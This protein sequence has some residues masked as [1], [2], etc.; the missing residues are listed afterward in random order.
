MRW[1]RKYDK[2]PAAL[3]REWVAADLRLADMAALVRTYPCVIR[4]AL[5]YHGIPYKPHRSRHS[6]QSRLDRNEVQRMYWDERMTQ[7]EIGL[8]LGC[9]GTTI[10]TFMKKAGIPSRKGSP[11]N[12]P[13]PWHDRDTLAR[14]M[15]TKTYAQLAAEWGCHEQTVIQAAA[16]HN[17]IHANHPRRAARRRE[18]HQVI[19]EACRRVT[20]GKGLREE[21]PPAPATGTARAAPIVTVPPDYPDCPAW[22]LDIMQPEAT[23]CP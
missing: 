4:K 5:D 6:K 11:Y 7:A 23:P 9:C 3:L 17:L 8:R 13:A 12:G 22:L 14:A 2:I 1:Q 15:L 19:R 20:A 16:R 10:G 18:L 21:R